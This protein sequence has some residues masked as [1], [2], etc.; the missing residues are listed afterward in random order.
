MK[1]GEIYKGKFT[2]TKIEIIN[3]IGR[4]IFYK[5]LE[6][7]EIYNCSIKQFEL[8]NFIKI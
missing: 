3:I 6:T 7:N 2:N 1:I 4:K 5:V 8:S